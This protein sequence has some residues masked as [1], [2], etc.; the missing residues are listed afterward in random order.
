MRQ[1]GRSARRSG[2]KVQEN[3]GQK[4]EI[5]YTGRLFL[6]ILRRESRRETDMDLMAQ[7]RREL[8]S[9]KAPG[10]GAMLRTGGREERKG[11]PCCLPLTFR[12]QEGRLFPVLSRRVPAH[13]TQH[14]ANTARSALARPALCAIQPSVGGKNSRPL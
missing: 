14:N 12:V 6:A 3:S 4:T 10:F 8:R 5:Q 13:S 1:D 2:N 7:G 9:M 11:T